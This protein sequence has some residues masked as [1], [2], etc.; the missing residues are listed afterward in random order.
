MKLLWIL[1]ATAV[2]LTAQTT[3]PPLQFLGATATQ[4]LFSYPDSG[5]CA[6]KV[7]Q[8]PAFDT[9]LHDVDPALFPGSNQDSRPGAISSGGVR[10]FLL[11]KRA[12]EQGLDG[13]FYS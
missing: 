10:Y 1:I 5:G 13:R 11:G 9:L 8:S 3:A 4:A 2:F 6:W 12:T 7:S